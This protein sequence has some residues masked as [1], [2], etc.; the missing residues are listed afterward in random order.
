M[1]DSQAKKKYVIKNLDELSLAILRELGRLFVTNQAIRSK[2]L[3]DKHLAK[4]FGS[5][6]YKQMLS[7]LQKL[8]RGG[9]VNKYYREGDVLFEIA[10]WQITREGLLKV[11]PPI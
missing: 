5:Y 2:V 3:W 11:M 4:S 9:L 6:T 7:R 10:Y 8:G 1:N